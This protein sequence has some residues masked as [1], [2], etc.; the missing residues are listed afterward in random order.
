MTGQTVSHYKILEK[1][2]G[3]G[4]GVVYKA[5]DLKLHRIVALKF[6]PP[7]LTRD[8]EAKKRFIHEA[9]AASALDHNNICVIHEID[10]TEGKLFICMNYYE[11]DT[12][13]KKIDQG[14]LKN[15]EAVDLAVQILKGLQ[16]A[17]EK[18]II[19]RDIK[20]ANIFITADGIVKILDFGLAKLSGYSALTKLGET[21]GTT[22]YMSPEQ[23]KGEKMD[24]RT[25]IWS[26]GVVLYEMLTGKL[27]FPGEYEQSVIYSILNDEP[28]PVTSLR[29]NIPVELE[30]II[31][32]TLR[33]NPAERYQHTD[34]LIVDL[35]SLRQETQHI[36]VAYPAA[37]QS[38]AFNKKTLYI[39]M[40][41]IF[42][43]LL[44]AVWLLTKEDTGGTGYERLKSIGVLPFVPFNKTNDDSVFADGIHDDILTQLSKISDLRV[45]ARTSMILYR[46]TKK[47]LSQI[48]NELDAGY[49]LE[50]SVRR[51]GNK[52]RITAQLIDTKTEG[53]VWAD[54]YDRSEAD[55]FAVQSEIAKRIAGELNLKLLPAEKKSIEG[56][57][58]SN[59]TAYNYYMKGQYY[60]KNYIDEAGN[61]KAA[62]MFDSAAY[63]DPEFY[64]AF[65]WASI[66]H[67]SL[68]I[69][70]NWD[71]TLSRLNKTKTMLD[72]AAAINP[73]APEV[74][75]AKGKYYHQIEENRYKALAELEP[76]L[77][78]W[79]QQDMLI[80]IG[81]IYQELGELQKARDIC[82]KRRV[83]DPV[84]LSGG[85]E[86]FLI[87]QRLREYEVAKREAEEY[88]ALHPDDPRAYN[89][90]IDINN[91]GFGNTK[92]A[93]KIYEEGK[94][95]PP[96]LFRG[97]ESIDP[98]RLWYILYLEREFDSALVLLTEGSKFNPV[99]KNMLL[100]Y[101]WHAKRELNKSRQSFS[102]AADMLSKMNLLY[103]SQKVS[104]AVCLAGSGKE[105]EGIKFMKE[106]LESSSKEPKMDVYNRM[107]WEE[108]L[109]HIYIFCNK[110]KEALDLIEDILKRPG[111]LTVWSLRQ[112]AL[113]DPLRNDVRFKNLV[114]SKAGQ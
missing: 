53:H 100:G 7:E 61:T 41:V 33:K 51:S 65:A 101:T 2:G 43:G 29:T 4:M 107:F 64:Q 47:R 71:N 70:R 52:I 46:D 12:L 42:V 113:Y 68:Y 10:E 11:G 38:S 57:L 102:Y 30:R 35:N 50:G 63:H 6:L 34:E 24:T 87:S 108:R 9:E 80:E 49:L 67:G 105:E 28:E 97:G 59:M 99:Q 91:L 14:L 21:L 103:H 82:R 104:M 17:H 111:T 90:M 8:E 78:T 79:P 114:T 36:T 93:R 62:E 48:G 20:P 69:V 13:K 5:E 44:I 26:V 19:H 16:K 3:G 23:A 95:L 89:W 73:D 55:I 27:P 66:V 22:P 112:G 98:F 60:W 72:N 85:W 39:P 83:I 54:V 25:D 81:D 96:N 56:K 31:Y 58:T 94:R 37:R 15:D 92:Q 84:S 18:G 106:V 110:H 76:L 88:L 86:S 40:V 77:N 45:I 32:K 109:V 75:F 74:R 1:L